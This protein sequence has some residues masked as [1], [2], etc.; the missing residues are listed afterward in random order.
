M[1]WSKYVSDAEI[2]GLKSRLGFKCYLLNKCPRDSQYTYLYET[3]GTV[4]FLD[5]CWRGT[6]FGPLPLTYMVRCNAIWSNVCKE[7][8]TGLMII[9][10]S[11]AAMVSQL[12]CKIPFDNICALTWHQMMTKFHDVHMGPLLQKE[13]EFP[14]KKRWNGC[15][16]AITNL[17]L[18]IFTHLVKRFAYV[19]NKTRNINHAV[20][21]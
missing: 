4:I 20:R 9:V 18:I 12:I 17:I 15:R 5:R 10:G 1:A 11:P 7:G 19:R 13:S 21:Y 16:I 3:N 6:S 14:I 2:S 8:T